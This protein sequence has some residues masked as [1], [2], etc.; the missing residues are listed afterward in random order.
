M[1]TCVTACLQQINRDTCISP[2][3]DDMD[4]GVCIGVLGTDCMHVSLCDC[5]LA[6]HD[7]ARSLQHQALLQALLVA[8][9]FDV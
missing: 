9:T 7:Y 1:A 4:C 5:L 6:T 8:P 2:G 3:H